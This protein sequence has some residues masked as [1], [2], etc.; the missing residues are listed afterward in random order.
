MIYNLSTIP[1]DIIWPDVYF[2]PEYGATQQTNG[3]EWECYIDDD[4]LYVYLIRIPDIKSV[5]GYGGMYLWGLHNQEKFDRYRNKFIKV[6]KQRGVTTEFIRK[7]PYLDSLNITDVEPFLSR[8]TFGV[9]LD[10]E[11]YWKKCKGDHRNM[12]RKGGKINYNFTIK[13]IEWCDVCPDS[14]FRNLYNSTMKNINADE[15]YIFSDEYYLAL[16]AV[17]DVYIAFASNEGKIVGVALFL[18]HTPYIHYHLSGS[19][20]SSN[21]I[22][23]FI[24]HGVIEWCCK[25]RHDLNLL[26]LGG[27]VKPGDYLEK[28]KSKIATDVYEYNIY[29]KCL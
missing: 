6:Q 14:P 17:K 15:N 24:I 19:D 10:Y 29:N 25:H 26:H 5:Y 21:C 11:L 2:T 7:N 3:F 12:V 16:L 18:V 4:F 27:G 13:K 28:F 9:Q 22:T 23:D 20:K 1:S 8:K